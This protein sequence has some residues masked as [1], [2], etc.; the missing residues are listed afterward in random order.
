MDRDLNFLAG[1]RRFAVMERELRLLDNAD[2]PTVEL[3]LLGNA[4]FSTT[5]LRLLDNDDSPTMEF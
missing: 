1:F 5:E 4:E 3:R 2:F